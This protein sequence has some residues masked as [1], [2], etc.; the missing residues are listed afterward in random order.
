[1]IAFAYMKSSRD[2]TPLWCCRLEKKG[3]SKYLTL[4]LNV[5]K[6]ALYDFNLD[7]LIY[8]NVTGRQLPTNRC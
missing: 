8:F 1:M 3:K 2:L 6:R 5:N 7:G 4:V